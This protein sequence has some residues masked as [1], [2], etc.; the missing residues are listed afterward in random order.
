MKTIILTLA[1]A[2]LALT[3]FGQDYKGKGVYKSFIVS[4]TDTSLNLS[5]KDLEIDKVHITDDVSIYY[6]T[7]LDM[8]VKYTLVNHAKYPSLTILTK[9]EMGEVT[10]MFIQLKHQ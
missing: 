9:D 6:C 2:L 8:T 7:M 1:I 3:S 5:G 4:A 10:K